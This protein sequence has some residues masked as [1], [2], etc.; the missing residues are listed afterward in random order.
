MSCIPLLAAGQIGGKTAADGP[1]T[2]DD[3][4]DL[5]LV[6]GG[7]VRN[8]VYGTLPGGGPSLQ[9]IPLAGSGLTLAVDQS[10]TGA[11]RFQAE[12]SGGYIGDGFGVP[13]PG[14]PGAST[15][16]SPGDITSFTHITFLACFSPV[17]S[18]QVF[19]VILETYPDPAYP[20]I[21]WSFSPAP[22]TTFQ[23]VTLDLRQPDQIDN[24]GGLTLEDLLARTR[25]LS[26]Y[27][28][29]DTSGGSE[30]SITFYVDD[31]RLV[32]LADP[33]PEPTPTEALT[34]VP[35]EV[36]NAY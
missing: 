31:I 34:G 13:V 18:G 7:V 28:Y 33:T 20:R 9:A 3:V 32:S 24:A 5:D 2:L 26:F 21:F 25:Y 27:C 35:P 30:K 15:L 23:Q 22:G 4:E 29:A 17:I 8:W 19:N 16:D 11:L 36:W 6:A 12:S 1:F 14:Q 10:P